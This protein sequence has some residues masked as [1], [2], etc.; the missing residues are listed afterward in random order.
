CRA[1]DALEDSWPGSPTEVG[2]RFDLLLAALA[3]DARATEALARA[4]ARQH[5]R[6]DLALLVHLPALLR[7]LDSL[8]P[9]DATEG[10][11]C[12][13]TMALG[14]RGYATGGAARGR[15]VPYLADDGELHDYCHV[16]GGCVGEMLTRLAA[17]DWPDDRPAL[18]ARRLALAPIVGEALQLTNILLD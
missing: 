11:L 5:A 14:M 2:E 4:A 17:H 1:A 6:A 15:A 7:V 8:A 13:R 16:V 18:A 3:R 10:R 12:V 9:D